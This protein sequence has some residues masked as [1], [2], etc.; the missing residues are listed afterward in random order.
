MSYRPDPE[1]IAVNA[2]HISWTQYSFYAFPTFSVIMHLL[3]KIQEEQASGITVIPTGQPK[4][5]GQEQWIC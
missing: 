2:F 4:F 1:A 3:K 5:S